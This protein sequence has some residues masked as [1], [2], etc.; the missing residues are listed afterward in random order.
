LDLGTYTWAIVDKGILE[1][2][3]PRGLRNT[4]L[5]RAVPLVR[6]MQTGTVHDYALMLQIAVIAGLF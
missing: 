1:I 6:A 3:G 2:L 4:I 5:E